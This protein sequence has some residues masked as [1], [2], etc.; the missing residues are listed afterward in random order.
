MCKCRQSL[1]CGRKAELRA[2]ARHDFDALVLTPTLGSRQ[3]TAP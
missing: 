2:L 3:L 1:R